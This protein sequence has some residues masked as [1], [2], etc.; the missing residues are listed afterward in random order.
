MGLPLAGEMM[1]QDP[2]LVDRTLEGG[3]RYVIAEEHLGVY[4]KPFLTASAS[5]RSLPGNYS[6]FAT[7]KSYS[8]N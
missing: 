4:R 7:T 2:L 5:G 1:T 8:R 6:Q 3:S